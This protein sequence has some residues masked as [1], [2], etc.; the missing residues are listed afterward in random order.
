MVNALEEADQNS[1]LLGVL[2]I[3]FSFFLCCISLLRL[4]EASCFPVVLLKVLALAF[5][6]F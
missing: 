2:K 6:L 5:P 4:G 3:C 1:A